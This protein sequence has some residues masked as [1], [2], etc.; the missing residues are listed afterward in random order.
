[1]FIM[2][3]LSAADRGFNPWLG[4]TKVYKTGICSFSDE[5]EAL[6]S[7]NK[8]WLDKRQDDVSEWSTYV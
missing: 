7:K 2:L 8:D 1:M 6:R 5:H 4:H 3:V